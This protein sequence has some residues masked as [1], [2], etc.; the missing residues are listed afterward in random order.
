MRIG[1]IGSG[2]IGG[3]LARL[4]AGAG[5]EVVLANSRGPESLAGLVSEIGPAATASTPAGAAQA[6]E[7]VVVA[8]PFLRYPDLP[9]AQL[10]GKVVVDATNYYAGRDGSF[11]DIESGRA[12]SSELL[13]AALPGATVVKAFN[14]IHYRHLAGDGV[15]ASTPGRRTIPIAGDDRAAKATVAGLIDQ[16][17]FDAYD[18][19]S[20]ADGRRFD[21]GTP[22]FNVALTSDEVAAALA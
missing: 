10:A 8:I 14:T 20:L 9:A 12:G 11:P 13:A 4:L 16:I 5:H 22:L 17:G 19:G 7:V 18:A 21:P 2:N 1:I 6:G 3:T 15:P